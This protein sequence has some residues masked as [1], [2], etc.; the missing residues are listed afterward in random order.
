MFFQPMG[1]CLTE[2]LQYLFL[3]HSLQVV[4]MNQA[5]RDLIKRIHQAR[6]QEWPNS[7]LPEDV[8]TLCH[9]RLEVLRDRCQSRNLELFQLKR[10][11]AL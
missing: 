8:A 5:A 10:V 1:T 4:Y 6:N 9:E 7:P 3:P 11:R 2:A